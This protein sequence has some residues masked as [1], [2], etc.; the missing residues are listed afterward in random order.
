MAVLRG[1]A[2]ALIGGIRKERI[3]QC[4]E[5][6]KEIA[7]LGAEAL[8]EGQSSPDQSH[9]L[10]LRQQ[11]LRDLAENKAR[12]CALATQRRLYVVGDKA[13][14]L[15]AWLERRDRGRNWF[16]TQRRRGG[17]HTTGEAIADAFA[18][19][20][21]QLYKYLSIHIEEECVDLLRDISSRF[22]LGMTGLT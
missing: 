8:S 22:S 18:T 2:A 21:E 3:L 12:L 4:T 11:E 13:N 6:E 14:K 10:Q 5:L 9:R 17:T 1:N 20:Y 19:Y 15:I 7:A 16:I